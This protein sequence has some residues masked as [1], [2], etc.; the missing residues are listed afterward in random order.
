[1]KILKFLMIALAIALI[2]IN[3]NVSKENN[4]VL[5]LSLLMKTVNAD[6]EDPP[7][8]EVYVIRK[9][10]RDC[11]FYAAGT[12]NGCENCAWECLP[13]AFPAQNPP[14][15]NCWYEKTCC[16]AIPIWETLFGPC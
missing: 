1:M 15:K 6:P 11:I 12:Q 5:S 16:M 9:C 3:L 2:A 14:K 8:G 13:V 4:D 10:Y 7:P